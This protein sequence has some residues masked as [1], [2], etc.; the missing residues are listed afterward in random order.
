MRSFHET[1]GL[2]HPLHCTLVLFP[3]PRKKGLVTIGRD[4]PSRGVTTMDILI[5]FQ[6]KIA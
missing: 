6:V 5:E 4:Q 3:D 2:P 1:L